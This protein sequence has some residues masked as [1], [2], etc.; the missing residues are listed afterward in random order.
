[1]PGG[2]HMLS[3]SEATDITALLCPTHSEAHPLGLPTPFSGRVMLQ[4]CLTALHMLNEAED[5]TAYKQ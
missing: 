5:V 1:M 2:L 3:L 4:V